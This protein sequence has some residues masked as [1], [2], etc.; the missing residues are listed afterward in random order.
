MLG[1]DTSKD[2][3]V[4]A[5]R[6]GQSRRLLWER[7]VPN[8]TEGVNRL[9]ALTPKETPW[10][11][12]PT[13]RHS[14]LAV[15]MAQACG[16]TVLMAPPRKAKFFLGSIQDRAK[17]DPIDGKGLSLFGL[18]VPLTTYPVKS[19]PIDTLDQLL[20]ARKGL[21]LARSSL[22]QQ[23]RDL[24]SAVAQ[25]ALAPAISALTSQIKAIDKEIGSRTEQTEGFNCAKQIRKVHGIGKV[26]AAAVTSRLVARRFT[27]PDQFVAYVGLDVAVRDSGRHH[28]QRRLTKQG[29]AELRRLLYLCAQAS[30][31]TK[32]SPFRAQYERE[33]AKG[34]PTTAALCAVARKMARLCWSLHK[35]GT[36]YD[37]S[38][39]GQAITKKPNEADEAK[40]ESKDE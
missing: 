39:V 4:V 3:L 28:G 24:P 8:S 15:Q 17:T 21:A 12:E 13:G 23:Q 32:D 7:E 31:R 29:D 2:K 19:E 20:K 27:H 40:P 36:T 34:L 5:L 11:I 22:T 26:T 14:L 9:L 16:R 38:R 18:C 1:I 35:H 30:V 37:P 25:E 6:D 10:V 33:L